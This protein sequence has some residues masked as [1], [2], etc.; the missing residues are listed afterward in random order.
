MFSQLGGFKTRHYPPL[1]YSSITRDIF[2]ISPGKYFAGGL[3]TDTLNG[4]LIGKLVV[5]GL[6]SLG[7]I[8]WSKKYG[9][10][11]FQYLNNPFTTRYFYKQGNNFYTSCCVTDS[12]NNQIGVLVK[13]DINGDTI[14]Q[15]IYRDTAEDV[16]PQ[17]VTASVD[18]GFLI[19]GF[20]QNWTTNVSPCLLIKTDQNGQE[21]WRKRIYNTN[22]DFCDGKAI[23]QDSASKKIVIAGYQYIGNGLRDHILITD[24]IGNKLVQRSFYGPHLADINDMIQTKDKKVVVAGGVY[25]NQMLG[26]NNL[27]CSYVLKF[28]PNMNQNGQPIWYNI[29][30]DP[31]SLLNVFTCINEYPNGDILI[32]GVIDTVLSLYHKNI[33]RFSRLASNGNILSNRY[34][35]YK[36]NLEN[37]SN[38]QGI[39]GLDITSD[40]GWVAGILQQNTPGPNPLFYV[41]YDST[42]CD[43]SSAYCVAVLSGHQESSPLQ[44]DLA[45]FPNP[46]EESLKIYSLSN[47]ALYIR[48]IDLTGRTVRQPQELQPEQDLDISGLHAGLYL[49]LI[50]Q[51]ERDRC[52]RLVKH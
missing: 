46:A 28:D 16:I 40:G 50:R 17:M 4:Y 19:T 10:L 2:E 30:F 20:F 18:G 12:N 35:N 14:W 31:P 24:S 27:M 38:I 26:S 25:K 47:K 15:K 32:G 41:K 3:I 22:N 8:L 44:D 6:D 11:N 33:L 13:F 5:T 48:I 49:C 52:L 36:S 39:Y 37:Q 1:A 42:G 51:G 9:N 23:L 45:L 34:Y 7:Q 43:T 21:L 29:T